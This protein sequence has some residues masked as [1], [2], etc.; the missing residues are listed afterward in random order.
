MPYSRR[1]LPASARAST[2][3]E[4]LVALVIVA[5]LLALLLTAVQKVRELAAFTRGQNQLRQIGLA[6]QQ[7]A[8]DRGGRLPRNVTDWDRPEVNF[9][10]PPEVRRPAMVEGLRT[11]LNDL[12]PYLDAQPLYD[13]YL[14]PN[15][16]APGAAKP[17][18]AAVFR[19]PLD[20]SR[21]VYESDGPEHSCSYVS[22]AQVFSVVR[23]LPGG[24]PDG[25]SNT[26]F[27]AEHYRVC[28]GTA[29]DL[30]RNT[31]YD[32]YKADYQFGDSWEQRSAPTFADY[33][34]SPHHLGEPPNA[35][36]YPLTAGAPPRSAA[37][38]G[39]TFQARPALAD[40]DPRQPNAASARGLQVG[41]G[42]GAVRTVRPGVSPFV[43]WAAVTP[44]RGE[45]EAPDF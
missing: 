7:Y 8:A 12:L 15:Y 42:D 28:R 5:V 43:L 37:A 13:Y 3:L 34:Y 2:L 1:R 6:A 20:P 29:F 35:D 26:V 33:G 45:V 16:P 23:A 30:F 19:N 31:N 27:F 14:G 44:D 32:R 21:S 24:V 38:D 10:D 9:L 4:L 22:N 18:P 39:V 17:G 40:C 11:A 36:Y 25:V 41:M